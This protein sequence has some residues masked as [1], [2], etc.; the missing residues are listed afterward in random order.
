MIALTLQG[1]LLM[2]P[3]PLHETRIEDLPV[4][5]YR[6]NEEMGQAAAAEASEIIRWAIR[7]KRQA[8]IIVATGNS[9]LT[10][11]AALK[12]ATAIDW[13]RV[14]I[15]HMDEYVGIDPEHPAS[16]PLF[17]HRHLVDHVKPG[18]FYPVPARAADLDAA[19]SEYETL[20]RAHP[21]DL[22]A[23][24]IGENGHLAFNDPPFADFSDPVWVKV[25]KLDEASRRQQ[26]GEGHFGSLEEV[27][28]HAITLTI[29]AL[30]AAR[31]VLA[32]VPEARKAE[33]V[34]KSLKGPISTDCPASILRKTPHAHLFLD[35]EAAGK[36]WLG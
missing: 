5:I 1:E 16:F 28:T 26:V 21:A 2:Y 29:P 13:S 11:L 34:F 3:Q 8:N 19:C 25:V 36:V 24:G 9:Q 4:S 15:F 10:F 23:L 33:A 32:I 14:N 6:T 27:P 35:A 7:E 18:A 17:L 31:R 20:L 30:L 12:E 22:C